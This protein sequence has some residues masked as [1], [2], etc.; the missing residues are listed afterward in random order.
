MLFLLSKKFYPIKNIF[1]K[2]SD[3]ITIQIYI[4]TIKAIHFYTFTRKTPAKT[5]PFVMY[6]LSPPL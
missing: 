1:T 5:G 3:A 6:P 4:N 2:V